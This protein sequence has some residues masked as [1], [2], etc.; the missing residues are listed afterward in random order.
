MLRQAEK[1]E[2]VSMCDLFD[3][4]QEKGIEIGHEEG[5]KEGRKEERE[6]IVINALKAGFPIISIVS[7]GIP[8]DEIRYFA[9]KNNLPIKN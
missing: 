1:G 3:Y 5:R 2:S 9:D 4:A 7:L 6:E 8:E